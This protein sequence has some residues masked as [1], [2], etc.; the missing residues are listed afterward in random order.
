MEH[1]KYLIVGGGVTADA[2]VRG[3]RELDSAGLIGVIST[4][5]IGP[6]DRP[7]LSKGPWK[8]KDP[9]SIWRKTANVAGVTFHLGATAARIDVAARQVTDQEGRAYSYEKLLLATSGAP[10]CLPFGEGSI[11]YFRTLEDYQRL[12]TLTERHDRFAVIGGERIRV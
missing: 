7:P 8:E 2:A 9:E 4:E 12:R 5:S 3:I 6:Y 11:I 10:R 1:Y